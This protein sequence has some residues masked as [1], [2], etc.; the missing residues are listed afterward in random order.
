MDFPRVLV[1]CDRESS[2]SG[3][4]VMMRIL[5]TGSL[6][7]LVLAAIAVADG[8][9]AIAQTAPAIPPALGMP[10]KVET[11]IGTLESSDGVPTLPPEPMT[12]SSKSEPC[13]VIVA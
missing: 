3:V 9:G 6:P 12:I 7:A 10:D 11:R 5:F 8:N 4:T 13:A 1:A 2:V